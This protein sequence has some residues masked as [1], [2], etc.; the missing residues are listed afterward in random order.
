MCTVAVGAGAMIAFGSGSTVAQDMPDALAWAHIQRA[1]SDIDAG[2][3]DKAERRF[4]WLLMH[5]RG[6]AE[7]SERYQHALMLLRRERPLRF[8]VWGNVTPS[9]NLQRNSSEDSFL[10]F[11]LDDP[12]SGAS[13]S[14]GTTLR[15]SHA[16]R[17]GHSV[18]GA[19]SLD[20]TFA[21]AEELDNTSL[22]FALSHE[23]L[24]VG[25]MTAVS[26]SRSVRG[27]KDLDSR[28]STPDYNDWAFGLSMT[29]WRDEGRQ[30][31][32]S[33]SL[34]QRDYKDRDYMDGLTGHLRASYSQPVADLG[35]L[36]FQGALGK[37]DLRRD[38]YSYEELELGIRFARHEKNGL[39]WELGLARIWRDYEDD[40][41]PL[42]DPRQD[43]THRISLGL[44]HDKL[45]LR[46][47]TPQLR[48]SYSDQ[49]SNVALY[50]FES[51]DCSASL[52]YDF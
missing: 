9:S 1:L 7:R 10:I 30:L 3:E 24:S 14:L 13:F 43:R 36:T 4:R 28:S 12:E 52:S 23:W 35:R 19:L 6:N 11:P 42:T 32:T 51:L 39:D 21:T 17:E 27:Y 22:S 2:H 37:A 20:R 47:M 46:D 15:F 5:D 41:A 25:R 29:E 18:T 38:V 33:I 49:S 31:S 45:K 48:C 50:A 16:Y 44:S 8:S 34:R 40:F 26:V